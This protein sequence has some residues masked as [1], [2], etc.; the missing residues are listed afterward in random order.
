MSKITETAQK[1]LEERYFL[2][3]ESTWEQLSER[4]SNHF[5]TNDEEPC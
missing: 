3:G 5:G 4:V 2:E 1:V